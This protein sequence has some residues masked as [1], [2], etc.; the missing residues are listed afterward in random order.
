MYLTCEAN[1]NSLQSTSTSALDAAFTGVISMNTAKVEEL[2]AF[3]GYHY[4]GSQT[5]HARIEVYKYLKE[6]VS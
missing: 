4:G 6:L 3:F 1:P 2:I 5:R